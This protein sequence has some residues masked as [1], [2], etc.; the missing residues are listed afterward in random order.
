MSEICRQ[1]VPKEK[2][3]ISGSKEEK[4]TKKFYD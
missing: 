1:I 4:S 3:K 2:R